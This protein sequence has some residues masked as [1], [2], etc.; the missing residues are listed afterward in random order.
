MPFPARTPLLA[1]LAAALVAFGMTGALQWPALAAPEAPHR[2][3]CRA[4]AGGHLGEHACECARC[5]E[6][7]HAAR[8]R[9]VEKLPPCH[10]AAARKALAEESRR[11]PPGPC[12]QGSC[13][14]P[15]AQRAAALPMAES[16][17][18]P[19]AAAPPAPPVSGLTPEACAEPDDAGR[20][21]P[22]PPP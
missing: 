1:R 2:C 9:D 20:V 13:G 4:G 10:R 3:A 21:P 7:T 15:E 18:L 14:A 19:D 12:F 6:Q 22:T 16:F 17:L 11:P 8:D 5:R